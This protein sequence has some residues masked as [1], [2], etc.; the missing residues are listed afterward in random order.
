MESVYFLKLKKKG[1]I[2]SL[3]LLPFLYSNTSVIDT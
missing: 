3:F 1:N 2:G